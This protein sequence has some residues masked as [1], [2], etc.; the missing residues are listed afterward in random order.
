MIKSV[1]ITLPMCTMSCFKLP[2]ELCKDL[3]KM[4]AKL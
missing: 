4:V 2:K 3:Y 1:V